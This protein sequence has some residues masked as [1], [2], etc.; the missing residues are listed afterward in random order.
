MQSIFFIKGPRKWFIATDIFAWE[1]LHL[2]SGDFR[3]RGAISNG[4]S[5]RFSSDLGINELS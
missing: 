4:L 3:H 1:T 5:V 2:L